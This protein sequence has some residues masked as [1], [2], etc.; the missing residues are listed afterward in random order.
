MEKAPAT[1]LTATL[2]NLELQAAEFFGGLDPLPADHLHVVE[3]FLVG[4]AVGGTTQLREFGD[5]RF[6]F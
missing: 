1:R 6:I 2:P 3:S 5:E 4:V